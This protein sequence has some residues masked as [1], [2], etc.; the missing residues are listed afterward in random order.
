MI[1]MVKFTDAVVWTKGISASC[2]VWPRWKRLSLI[3]QRLDAGWGWE[4][5]MG[6]GKELF[7]GD[8][9]AEQHLRFEM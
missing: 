7:D 1:L 4:T 8:W 5:G 9:E 2:H 6:E 3:L